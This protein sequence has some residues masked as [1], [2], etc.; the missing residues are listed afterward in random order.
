MTVTV[1]IRKDTYRDSVILM[2]LSNKVA[3]LDGVLQAGV[4]MGSR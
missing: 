3:E 4:V 1:I 2:R